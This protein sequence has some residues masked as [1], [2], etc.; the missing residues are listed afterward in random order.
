MYFCEW[1]LH[2]YSREDLLE[3]YKPECKGIGQTA[4]RVEMPEEGKNTLTFQN[5]HKQL[6]APF[7]LYADFEGPELDPMKSNAQK[8]QEHEACSYCYVVVHCNGQTEPPVV[9]HRPNAA[10]HFLKA[11]Q[12]EECKIKAVLANPNTMRMTR[13][14]W[15]AY[16]SATTCHICEKPLAGDRQRSLP[17]HRQYQG[18]AHNACNFKLCLSPKTTSVPVVFHNLRGYD[19]HLLLQAI[20]MV[21]VGISCIPNNIEKYISFSVGQLR[22]IDSAQILLASLDRLVAANKPEIFKITAWYEPAKE[23]RKLLLQ[24]GVYP[25]EYTDSWERFDDPSLP[26]KEAF[27]SKLSGSDISEEDYIH[28]QQVWKAFNCRTLGDYHDL[29]NRTDVLLLADVFEAFQKACLRQYGLDPAHYYTSPGL[30]WDTLLKKT[31]IE[32]ELLI[33]YYQHLFIK[34]G[35]QGGIS[36]M[37]K[38]HA[39]ANNPRVEGYDPEKPNNHIL[40]LDANNLY[41]WAM[42]QFLPKVGFRCIEDCGQM[43]KTITEHPA[44]DQRALSLRWIWNIQKSCTRRTM[45]TL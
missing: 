9:N 29:L 4:V 17:H 25:Y 26:P 18:A 24:K 45:P 11:L 12:K 33:N 23:K 8:T 42:S 43:A 34:K 21:D 27:Y 40:Y 35:V 20:S 36:M 15:R 14:D 10:A 1:C 22:F 44:D 19:P 3:A 31:S 7:I 16:N 13:E 38:R 37:S 28:T 39:R 32:L 2:G 41:G 30:S 6:P 5:H